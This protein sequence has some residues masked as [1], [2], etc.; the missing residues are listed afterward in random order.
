MKHNAT[1]PAIQV[2]LHHY[3]KMMN[4]VTGGSMTEDAWGSFL[5]PQTWKTSRSEVPSGGWV[6]KK[7]SF[8]KRRIQPDL[9]SV[10]WTTYKAV[11]GRVCRQSSEPV[12]GRPGESWAVLGRWPQGVDSVR[13][14]G[15]R[16]GETKL[17]PGTVQ[18]IYDEILRS[19]M[20]PYTDKNMAKI[21]ARGPNFPQ[22]NDCHGVF[23]L[24]KLFFDANSQIFIYLHTGIQQCREDVKNE[25]Y[26]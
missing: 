18:G 19:S 23:R 4:Q 17:L 10:H 6:G 7:V 20:F 9:E 25:V 5:E 26:N 13:Q 22:L 8:E 2:L 14:R 24:Q 3:Q 11:W 16:R 15:W 1:T 12:L 21:D